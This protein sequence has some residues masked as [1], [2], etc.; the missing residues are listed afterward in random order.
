[1]PVEF[2]Q[3]RT[4]GTRLRERGINPMTAALNWLAATE[5][6]A[7][8]IGFIVVGDLAVCTRMLAAEPQV[9]AHDLDRVLEVIWASTTE[10]VLGVRARLESWPAAVADLEARS[11]G[12]R[13]S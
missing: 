6:A 1:H 13:P 9:S 12:S 3:A 5:R 11:S 7:D 2:D 4:I 10:E 8:R